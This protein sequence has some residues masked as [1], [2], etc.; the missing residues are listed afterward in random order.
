MQT[1]A[2]G[3][4]N[5]AANAPNGPPGIKKRRRHMK[6]ILREGLEA[7]LRADPAVLEK[8]RPKTGYGLLV[9]GLVLEAGKCKATPLKT[10]MSLIDWAGEEE[11]GDGEEISDDTPWDWNSD[12]VW[13][14]TP[15]AAPAAE[16]P[17]EGP[18]KDELRWRVARLEEQGD[19]EQIEKVKAAAARAMKEP[20]K[21]APP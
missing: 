21:P 10:V 3:E 9:R 13:T 4:G 7:A 5:G 16:E 19:W 8:C 11:S 1:R 12:G 6:A 20:P 2:N 14:T 18:H 17:M 15:E